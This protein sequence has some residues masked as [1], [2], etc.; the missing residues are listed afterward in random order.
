MNFITR[1]IMLAMLVVCGQAFAQGAAQNYPN[2]TIRIIVPFPAGGPTDVLARVIGQRMSEDWG[3][4]VVIENRPGANTAIGA[5]LV[6]KAPPDGYTLLA[7]MDST[8][9]MNPVTT[10]NLPYDPFKDFASITLAANNTSLLTVRAA[11]GP[12]TVQELIAK[13][14]ANPGKLNYGAGTITTRLAGYL[15]N[16]MAGIDVV[17]VPYKGSADVVQGLLTGSTEFIVDGIA[18]SL[19]LIQ[20][21]KLRALAKL[22]SRPLPALPDLKPLAVAANLPSLDDISTWTALVAPTGTP[23]DIIEKIQRAV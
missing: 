22:N 5:Q 10:S 8:M 7:A 3:Q 9:V 19:P 18:A 21:G 14:K 11:D 12:K 2:K 13:A 20:S 1:I 16:R 17:F 6:A 15:F 4:P 23:P